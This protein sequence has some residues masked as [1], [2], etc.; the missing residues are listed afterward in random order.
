MGRK[1]KLG[2][3]GGCAIFKIDYA[4]KHDCFTL[5]NGEGKVIRREEYPVGIFAAMIKAVGGME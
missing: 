5:E 3:I 2:K 4:N 1:M